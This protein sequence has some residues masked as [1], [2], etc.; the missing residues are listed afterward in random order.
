MQLT[1]NKEKKGDGLTFICK[2]III[3]LFIVTLIANLWPV[4]VKDR[5]EKMG[6]N[7]Y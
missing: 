4:L 5:M 3:L 1:V 2:S 7:L 6:G